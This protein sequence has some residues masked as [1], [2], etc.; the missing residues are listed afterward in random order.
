M[1]CLPLGLRVDVRLRPGGKR[2]Q[3]P[4]LDAAWTIKSVTYWRTV[5]ST[6]AVPKEGIESMGRRLLLILAIDAAGVVDG[7]GCARTGPGSEASP[8]RARARIALRPRF[9][10]IL[11]CRQIGRF[12]RRR[13]RRRR[14]RS[15]TKRPRA[16]RRRKPS[17]T[18]PSSSRERQRLEGRASRHHRWTKTSCRRRPRC[19]RADRPRQPAPADSANAADSTLPAAE[20]LPLGK[21][22]VAVTVDVQA[23]ASMNLNKEATLKLIVR[24]TGIVR[25]VQRPGRRR[26]P[27]RPA[28]TS[29]ACP[30]CT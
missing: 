17:R 12:R 19:R 21:Q 25:R 15:R 27:R 30:R 3:S 1:D 23:P 29:R 14:P 18:R 13:D 20:R 24:N 2:S 26:A 9:R 11:R 16:S 8:V 4:C 7:S 5:A 28:I 22:S 6:G 10:A